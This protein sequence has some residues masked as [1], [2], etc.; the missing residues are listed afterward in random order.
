MADQP[1]IKKQASKPDVN[2]A[3]ALRTKKLTYDAIA[4]QCGYSSASACHKAIMHEM[5]RRVVTSI[6]E[7]R[8]EEL[9]ILDQLHEECWELAVDKDN[10][11]RLFAVDRLL[12]IS[13]ARRKLMGLD[14][15]PE[16]AMNQNIVVVREIPQG[17]LGTAEAKSE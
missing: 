10:K 16:N 7:L 8:C 5:Q 15:Q 17:Y 1:H 14:T 3:L 13:E 9:F 11:S 2:A 4:R 12:Q 6:K